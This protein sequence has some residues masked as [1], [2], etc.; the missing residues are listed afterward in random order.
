MVSD[1]AED[2]KTLDIEIF[3]KIV[4]NDP[5]MML[6]KEA[7]T[8]E[9]IKIFRIFSGNYMEICESE[10]LYDNTEVGIY[11]KISDQSR[12]HS[13]RFSLLGHGGFQKEAGQ[14]LQDHRGGRRGSGS[15]GEMNKI[16]SSDLA[17]IGEISA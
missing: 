14:G 3:E 11:N 1:P 6:Y 9:V 4:R 12:L 7:K 13:Q 15:S 5:M 8:D 17:Q 2:I 10:D 16:V